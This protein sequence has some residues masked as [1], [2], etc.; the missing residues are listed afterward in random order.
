MKPIYKEV[1][2]NCDYFCE[3]GIYDNTFTCA[4][5]HIYMPKGCSIEEK[6]YCDDFILD[7]EKREK[8]TEYNKIVNILTS[9]E[10]KELVNYLIE[11]LDCDDNRVWFVPFS[12]EV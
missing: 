12:K 8:S 10:H 3:S 9:M 2:A 7:D 11:N 6:T 1:C 5:R 4:Y